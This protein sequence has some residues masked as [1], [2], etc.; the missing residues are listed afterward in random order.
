MRPSRNAI[1]IGYFPKRIVPRPDWLNAP[2]VADVCSVSEC[3]SPGPEDWISY[4]RHNEIWV[5]DTAETASSLITDRADRALFALLAYRILPLKFDVGNVKPLAVPRLDVQELPAD[6][7][8]LG[9][10]IVSRSQEAGFECSPLSCNGIAETVSVNDHCLVDDESTA[11]Q[12]ARDFSQQVSR[13]EPG[14]YY[15]IEVWRRQ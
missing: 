6:F 13:C 15:V 9:F 2:A 1:L 12:L 3:M 8:F 4:W 10:D 5:Y 14:P 7:T 11:I